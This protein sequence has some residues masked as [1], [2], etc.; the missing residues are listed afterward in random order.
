[1]LVI[2]APAWAAFVAAA[3]PGV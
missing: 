3:Q 1:M 2:P